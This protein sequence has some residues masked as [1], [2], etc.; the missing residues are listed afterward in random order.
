M[1]TC[2]SVSV[3]AGYI[4]RRRDAEKISAASEITPTIKK[5]ITVDDS[6]LLLVGDINISIDPDPACSHTQ[7]STR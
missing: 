2:K 5:H 4:L 7:L 1:K 6:Q 3:M